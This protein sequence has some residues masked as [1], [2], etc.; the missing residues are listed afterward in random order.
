MYS[1]NTRYAVATACS[2]TPPGCD[3]PA[4][5]DD[6]SAESA[7][8]VVPGKSDGAG[9]P[10][11]NGTEAPTGDLKASETLRTGPPRRGGSRVTRVFLLVR[12]SRELMD[13]RTRRCSRAQG[14]ARSRV[15]RAAPTS[16]PTPR[17]PS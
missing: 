4:E 15:P 16:P 6:G 12:I 2:T 3:A 7:G 13:G 5:P 14:C 8:A 17:S 10:S 9:A 11:V 1:S